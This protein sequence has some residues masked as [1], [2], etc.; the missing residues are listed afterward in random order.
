MNDI[1]NPVSIPTNA[2]SYEAFEQ[3]WSEK[4]AAGHKGLDRAARKNW[5]YAKYNAERAKGVV[6]QL[7]LSEEIKTLIAHMPA[8]TWMVITE[9]WCVDSAFILPVIAAMADLNQDIE[10]RIVPRDAHPDVMD[11]YLTNGTRSI[12][13]LVVFDA[14]GNELFQWG[15]RPQ[16][17]VA[18]RQR[19][20]EAGVEKS[21]I[22]KQVIDAY[23]A[24]AWKDVATELS[25]SLESV[26]LVA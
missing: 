24:G 19:L 5:F 3:Q 14:S 21:D 20:V 23:G 7:V 8:Q 1:M 11:R 22:S 9:D 6:E 25:A 18:F 13:K 16:S 12:P 10:L 17:I 26:M 2:L 4:L 15:P